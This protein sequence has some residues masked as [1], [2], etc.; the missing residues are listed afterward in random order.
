MLVSAG[1]LSSPD[2]IT[3]FMAML[4]EM[5][6]RASSSNSR[7]VATSLLWVIVAWIVNGTGLKVR[8]TENV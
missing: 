7:I 6:S 8:E 1:L 5:V 4:V 2:T 3:C